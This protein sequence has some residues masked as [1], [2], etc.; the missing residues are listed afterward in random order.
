MN[1]NF[2][3]A[4]SCCLRTWM[5]IQSNIE[6]MFNVSLSDSNG[7]LTENMNEEN[8]M[9]TSKSNLNSNSI[10]ASVGGAATK[11]G[12]SI[13]LDVDADDDEEELELMPGKKTTPSL[14]SLPRR[15]SSS[16]SSNAQ[17]SFESASISK[18]PVLA[19]PPSAAVA[20]LS[21][22][23]SNKGNIGNNAAKATQK[24]DEE[25]EWNDWK[26]DDGNED[27]NGSIGIHTKKQ[28]PTWS[29]SP[30][31][32]PDLFNISGNNNKNAFSFNTNESYRNVSPRISDSFSST[33][34]TAA[35]NQNNT[36]KVPKKMKNDDY[37]ETESTSPKSQ[38][39]LIDIDE[40]L[41]EGMTPI[42]ETK[43]A[44]K[45]TTSN[46]SSS[47]HTS[48]SKF[49]VP[50]TNELKPKVEAVSVDDNLWEAEEL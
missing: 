40:S 21:V 34:P 44:K 13:A 50:S 3:S 42:I 28:S 14:S 45:S 1:D 41:F 26:D 15:S 17:K 20:G 23:A 46:A 31:Q 11:A 10:G 32:S 30:K 22:G 12:T 8:K 29:K 2:S 4:S 49:T 24:I 38:Q 7:S 19:P 37:F 33:T 6:T 35:I 47:I 16:T 25:S 27:E 43:P 39:Q 18:P 9:L 48:S 5:L 36:K